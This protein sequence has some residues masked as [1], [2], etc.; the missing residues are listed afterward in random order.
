MCQNKSNNSEIYC[1]K[2]T[3]GELRNMFN[4]IRKI[5]FHKSLRN[6]STGIG[7]TFE[8]LIGKKEDSLCLPDYKG[9]EIKTKLGYSKSSMTLFT[10]NPQ[11]DDDIKA[12][13]FLI[14]KFGYTKKA[15][16][17]LKRF[18]CCLYSNKLS[19]LKSNFLCKLNIDMKN[20][21]LQMLILNR[22]LEIID[23]GIYW[24]LD[25][26]KNKLY[27]KLNYLAL[28]K[29]YPYKINNEIYYKYTSLSF[30]KLKGFSNFLELLRNDNVQVLFSIE[31]LT[32]KNNHKK[33]HNRGGTFRIN[34]NKIDEL[35]LKM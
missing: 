15:D 22:N 20:N 3:M 2:K 34:I 25:I 8:T 1:I 30:Y 18:T 19:N 24:N 29:G 13:D 7:Y 21:K 6:G 11:R 9:I 16:K 23:N 17:V 26:L 28:V 14:D 35:F 5:P 10:S 33:I 4:E 31:I 32:D 27:T 12:I